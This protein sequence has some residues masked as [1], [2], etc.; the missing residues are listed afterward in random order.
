[1]KLILGGIN[2]NYLSNILEQAA[3][4]IDGVRRTEQVW[5]AVAYAQGFR[6][7]RR[8]IQW[9][10]DRDIPLTFWGRLDECVAVDIEILNQ[11]LHRR[12]PNYVCKLVSHHHA[13]VIWWRGY[14]VYI[15]SANLTSSA[16]YKNVEA[17]CFFEDAELDD[18]Q[19]AALTKLFDTLDENASA[20]TEEL[21]DHM[22]SRAKKLKQAEIEAE[23]FWSHPSLKSWKGLVATTPKKASDRQ[24][25]AFLAEWN[26]TLQYLRD[27]AH[28]VSQPENR[29]SW[30]EPDV[31]SGAQADQF[32]HAHYYHR[33]FDG[34]R[35]DYARHYEE[36]KHRREAALGDAVQWW[37]SLPQAP[38]GEDTAL[39]TTSAMLAEA[40]RPDSL[41]TLSKSDFREIAEKVHAMVEYARRVPNIA[42]GLPANASRQITIPEKLDALC[43]HLWRQKTAQGKT[44]LEVLD[45][46]LY[47]GAT[48]HLPDRLWQAV[49]DPNWKIDRMGI[50]TVGELVGW[51]IPDKFPPRNGRTSKALRSLGYDVRV[52]VG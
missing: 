11:F 25:D 44:V 23:S 26:G 2:G 45:H 37:R 8:L 5:A 48:D 46:I 32:L 33:T 27:I 31:S 12:S 6:D 7:E 40:L 43:E 41:P 42:V 1:M 10:F 18:E 20:L 35:A 14:G 28:L 51:A 3:L 38:S 30:V 24:R 52:H 19:D 39:N 4:E 16:W 9:C 49:G 36:N 13:K 21:R 15:G 47:G 34:R 22:I 17:G 29:P 50:S